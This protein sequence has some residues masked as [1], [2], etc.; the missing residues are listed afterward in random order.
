MWPVLRL[1]LFAYGTI[2]KM[3]P[4]ALQ[5]FCHQGL[6][7]Y[8]MLSI[9][10]ASAAGMNACSIRSPYSLSS[11]LRPVQPPQLSHGIH[12]LADVTFQTSEYECNGITLLRQRDHMEFL[13]RLV[14]VSMRIVTGGAAGRE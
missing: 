8:L 9:A 4:D 12:C 2:I 3:P 7:T 11:A 6:E 13:E 10:I 14:A 1:A 5:Q